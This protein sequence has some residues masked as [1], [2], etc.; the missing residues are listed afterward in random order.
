MRP[1]FLDFARGCLPDVQVP[2]FS[3]VYGLCS[4]STSSS[5]V[6][7]NKSL[8]REP[9]TDILHRGRICRQ[10]LTQFQ[11]RSTP[12]S[13]SSTPNAHLSS[14]ETRRPDPAPLKLNLM[15]DVP[16]LRNTRPLAPSS[17]TYHQ[18]IRTIPQRTG[19]LLHCFLVPARTHQECWDRVGSEGRVLGV[20][21]EA[22]SREK[23]YR[24]YR[25]WE[26]DGCCMWMTTGGMLGCWDLLRRQR[27]AGRDVCARAG[28]WSTVADKLSG[29]GQRHG[30]FFAVSGGI[31]RQN[32]R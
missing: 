28:M 21:Q 15:R 31:A 12:F 19:C 24:E 1:G 32:G 4:S 17:S 8:T 6:F 7:H 9:F 5:S 30:R 27:T 18:A 11:H 20:C 10:Q 2:A 25:C 16:P 13:T 29:V 22:E 14:Q 26:G 3:L 23:E